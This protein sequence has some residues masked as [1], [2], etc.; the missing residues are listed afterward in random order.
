MEISSGKPF[1]KMCKEMVRRKA[2][3]VKNLKGVLRRIFL[4]PR[5]LES[6]E[7]A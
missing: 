6:E 1:V 7:S 4:E 2:L 3:G 5:A